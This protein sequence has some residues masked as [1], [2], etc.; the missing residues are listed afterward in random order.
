VFHMF[1]RVSLKAVGSFK[2]KTTAYT[3]GVSLHAASTRAFPN[4]ALFAVHADKAVTAFDL[5]DIARTL[6]LSTDCLD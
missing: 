5:G 3:D 1:D 2:G 4:G 6:K